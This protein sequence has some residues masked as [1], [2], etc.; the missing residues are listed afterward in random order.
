MVISE[1]TL[2]EVQEESRGL[3]SPKLSQPGLGKAP[4]T[5]D[6]VDRTLPVHKLVIPMIHPQ[7][8]GIPHIYESVIAPP[9]IRVNG[10]LKIHLSSNDGLKG[11]LRDIRDDLSID[12]SVPL[13]DPEHDG[14]SEGSSAPFSL[15]SSRS[16]VGFINL[17]LPLKGRGLLTGFDNSLP[18]PG[19]I[20]VHRIPAQDG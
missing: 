14:L 9:A 7:V 17:N 4:K 15:D 2:F 19:K 20:T 3:E 6:S 11:R 12:L 18:D 13:E 5:L 10:R 8:L 16:K 1:L